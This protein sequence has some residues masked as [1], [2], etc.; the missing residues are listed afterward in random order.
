MKKLV[1]LDE[2]DGELL[3]VAENLGSTRSTMNALGQ[4]LWASV[5]P[6]ERP[7]GSREIERRAKRLLQAWF[8]RR[9]RIRRLIKRL[10]CVETARL[11]HLIDWA[12]TDQCMSKLISRL[13]AR[14]AERQTI[15]SAV[16]D[17]ANRVREVDEQWAEAGLCAIRAEVAAR[18]RFGARRLEA[19][20]TSSAVSEKFKPV[21]GNSLDSLRGWACTALSVKSSFPMESGLFDLVIIDEASQC[22]LAAVLPLAYRAKRLAVIGDP[23]QLPPIVSLGDGVLQKI[24]SQTV[25]KNDDL[26]RRGLHHKDGSAYSAFEFAA[27]PRTPV[28]L[29]EHYRCHPRI[30]RWFNRTFYGGEI[31]VLTEVHERDQR[32]RAMLWKDVKGEAERPSLGKVGEIRPKRSKSLHNL[33]RYFDPFRVSVSSLRSS[34]RHTSSNTSRTNDTA[35]PPWR[36]LTSLAEPHTDS[37]GASVMRSSS[38]AWYPQGC[39]LAAPAGSRGKEIS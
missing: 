4:K 29:D 20:N 36:R 32:T 28:L 6:P 14:R 35:N 5:T 21:V 33:K 16:G 11:E 1:Q 12:R 30:A 19:F 15:K 17:P 27:R 24:A 2:L 7:I 22:S 10:G 18:I 26:R 9:F 23:S 31:T 34:H 38:L 37:R 13:V 25:L 3:S 8:F 39:R